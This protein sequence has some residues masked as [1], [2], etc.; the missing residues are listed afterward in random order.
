MQKL[1]VPSRGTS[2]SSLKTHIWSQHIIARPGIPIESQA[3]KEIHQSEAWICEVQIMKQTSVEISDSQVQTC[4]VFLP[5]LSFTLRNLLPN[6]AMVDFLSWNRTPKKCWGS[7]LYASLCQKEKREHAPWGAIWVARGDWEKYMIPL[8]SWCLLST[9]LFVIGVSPPIL[10]MGG[11]VIKPQDSSWGALRLV[12]EQ[13]LH[14][15]IG[16]LSHFYTSRVVQDFLHQQYPWNKM[17]EVH[18]WKFS[19]NPFFFYRWGR[20]LP[21]KSMTPKQLWPFP[22]TIADQMF[23]K[24]YH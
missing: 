19:M 2:A 3:T 17:K 11:N 12:R 13:I 21:G 20:R 8:V 7:N 15:L 4:R 24:K 1:V 6:K 10:G 16:S 18:V 14:Q 22:G 9:K 23:I 5:F